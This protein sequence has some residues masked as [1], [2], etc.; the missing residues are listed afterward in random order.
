LLIED[1]IFIACLGRLLPLGL[2][3]LHNRSMQRDGFPARVGFRVSEVIPHTSTPNIHLHQ[4]EVDVAPCES[5]EFRT[6]QASAT[7]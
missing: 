7:C 4:F 5:D 6:P 3:A 2:K 1:E